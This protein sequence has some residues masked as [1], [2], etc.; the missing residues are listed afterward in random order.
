[1]QNKPYAFSA[2]EF[3][4]YA[5]I[6]DSRWKRY[7]DIFSFIFRPFFSTAFARI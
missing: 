2:Q 7:T 1:M 4:P 5:W 3:Y 6:G